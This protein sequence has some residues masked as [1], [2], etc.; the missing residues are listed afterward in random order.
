MVTFSEF[1]DE[2]S[3]CINISNCKNHCKGCHSKYLWEDIG[4][5]LYLETLYALI[6]KNEGITC[7][8]LMGGDT[9]PNYVNTL[10]KAVKD[11]YNIKV[12]WYSGRQ[13]LNKDIDP[14]WF[15]FIKLGSYI[16]EKGPLNNPNTNQRMYKVEHNEGSNTLID[17]TNKF[18]K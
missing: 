3:L 1:P 8:G 4:E 12:G 7:V 5:P 6:D 15:D 18:W 9:E 11:L 17:I 13:M 10:A 2:I 16:E 14:K